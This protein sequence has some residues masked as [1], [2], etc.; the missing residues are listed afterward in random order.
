VTDPIQ[1]PE[2][3]PASAAGGRHGV[4]KV[5]VVTS[6]TALF[7]FAIVSTS[8]AISQSN[9]T[10]RTDPTRC[11]TTYLNDMPALGAQTLPQA[12]PIA[13]MLQGYRRLGD[14]TSVSAFLVEFYAKGS[15]DYP[16][17]EGFLVVNGTP[18]E[19]K[20]ELV[21]GERLDRFG[22]E[23]GRFLAPIG[24]AYPERAL[25][26]ANLDGTNG[27][28]DCDY[29]SYVVVRSVSVM[30]GPAAPAFGQDGG[31]IQYFLG[32]NTVCSLVNS[33]VL[34]RLSPAGPKDTCTPT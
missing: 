3:H 18:V 11:S 15:W 6:A 12:G 31:G 7:L 16:E 1:D 8:V 13:V 17:P 4:A 9:A 10:A 5:A 26:P 34:K 28:V 32:S 21:P 23:S 33:H 19:G 2:V 27:A 30:A 22:T 20:A 29:H 14:N 24:T 25:P